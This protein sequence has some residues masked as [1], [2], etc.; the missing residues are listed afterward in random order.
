MDSELLPIPE[1]QPR[2]GN[3]AELP[4]NPQGLAAYNFRKI[5]QNGF[6]DGY[7]AY[8]HSM[9]WFKDHLYVGTTRANLQCSGGRP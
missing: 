5:S 8:P 7:N 1:N 9:I 6:G 3:L 4:S 2:R